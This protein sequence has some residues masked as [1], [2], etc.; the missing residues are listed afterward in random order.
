MHQMIHR[1]C[2][3]WE[4]WPPRREYPVIEGTLIRLDVTRPGRRPGR[5]R[6]EPAVAGIPAPVRPG[7]RARFL[8]S[9]LGW[10]KPMLRDPAA[11]DRWTWIIIACHAQLHLARTLAADVRLPWQRPQSCP[12]NPQVMTP[13]RV[14]AGFRDVRETR[15]TPASA[16]KTGKVG[17]RPAP[18]LEEQAQ[19]TPP[20]RRQDQPQTTHH[21]RQDPET[22]KT[23]TRDE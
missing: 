1:G 14:R 19:G 7:A 22:G 9:R 5:R 3:G 10:D 17:P 21:R 4:D 23:D 6:G 16:G 13:G 12:G 8:K 15:G 11:A 18:G 20:A 2:G